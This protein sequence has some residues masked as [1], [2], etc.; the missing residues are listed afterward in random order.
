SRRRPPPSPLVPYTTLFRS[1]LRPALPPQDAQER[2]RRV[3]LL[4]V[5]R[6][7]VHLVDDVEVVHDHGRDPLPGRGGGAL[8]GGPGGRGGGLGGLR[9]LGGR[10]RGL[11]GNVLGELS[12]GRTSPRPARSTRSR[13]SART[14]PRIDRSS[15]PSVRACAHISGD[16]A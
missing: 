13:R 16:G 3:A 11:L 4:R 2:V 1:H 14:P 6:L 10:L 5:G 12:H 9:R 7:A 15:T 8:G